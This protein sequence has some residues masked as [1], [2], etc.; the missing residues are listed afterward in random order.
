MLIENSEHFERQTLKNFGLSTSLACW[1]VFGVA[2]AGSDLLVLLIGHENASASVPMFTALLPLSFFA[3]VAMPFA[4]SL[5]T[6][7]CFKT[8]SGLNVEQHLLCTAC[9]QLL[10]HHRLYRTDTRRSLHPMLV[11]ALSVTTA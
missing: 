7:F 1:T 6:R 3:A 10:C 2:A 4:Q 9:L 8:R 5:R 11:P